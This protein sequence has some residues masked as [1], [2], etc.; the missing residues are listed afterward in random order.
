MRYILNDSGYIQAVSFNNLLECQNKTCTEYTG[1]VPTGY[2]TLAEWSENA[3]INAYKIVDSNLVFDS[4]EDARLQ[5]L[6]ANQEA[7]D[8]EIILY[9]NSS[10]TTGTITLRQ[11]VASFNYIEIYFDNTGDNTGGYTK[12][13][14]PD[15][16][17]IYLSM[18]EALWSSK[19][20]ITRTKYSIS[21]TTLTPVVDTAGYIT[22]DGTSISTTGGTNYLKIKRV[23]GY[24]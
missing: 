3:N 17:Y 24:M 15:G 6:W 7:S 19:T 9:E 16:K 20:D 18:I 14:Q 10:G 2:E 8:G 4:E 5:S 22:V 21:G 11:S 1:T 13:F 12:L 23:I